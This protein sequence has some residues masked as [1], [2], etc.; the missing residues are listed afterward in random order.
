MK[1]CHLK[2]GLNANDLMLCRAADM[3]S[4][5]CCEEVISIRL[6]RPHLHVVRIRQLILGHFCEVSAHVD[7]QLNKKNAFPGSNECERWLLKKN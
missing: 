5:T 4:P 3:R 2:V 7:E 6:K 1:M